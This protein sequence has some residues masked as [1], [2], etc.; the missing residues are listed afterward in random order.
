MRKRIYALSIIFTLTF[1]SILLAHSGRTDS[2]GGHR[3]NKNASGLGSY[4]YHCGGYPA[5]LHNNGICPYKTGYKTG[6]G[7]YN[8]TTSSNFSNKVTDSKQSNAQTEEKVVIRNPVT[9]YIDDQ[10]QEGNE[11]AYI[12]NGTTF[13]KLRTYSDLAGATIEHD[14]SQNT[15]TAK[16]DFG[17]IKLSTTPDEYVVMHTSSDWVKLPAS[18]NIING[19]ITVP[20]RTMTEALG[21]TIEKYDSSTNSLY[22]VFEK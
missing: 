17:W 1:A 20:I 5:H 21:G 9:L 13:I 15:Y 3:D 12:E 18:T 4:H 6:A 2:R 19:S 7:G 16:N 22:V 11:L 14:A 8:P 10:K